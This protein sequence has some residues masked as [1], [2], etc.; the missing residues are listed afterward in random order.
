MAK[1]AASAY[2]NNN[3]QWLNSKDSTVVTTAVRVLDCGD[4]IEAGVSARVLAEF[5]AV[6]MWVL[7]TL[8][9]RHIRCS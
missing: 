4:A 6:C 8:D 3:K 5:Y 1:M 9:A 2:A 7:A